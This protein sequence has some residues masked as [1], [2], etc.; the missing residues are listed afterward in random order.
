MAGLLPPPLPQLVTEAV[1]LEAIVLLA[2]TNP[3]YVPADMY[4]RWAE[5]QEGGPRHDLCAP[6]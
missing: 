5:G 4:P 1:G 3:E 2:R 6:G